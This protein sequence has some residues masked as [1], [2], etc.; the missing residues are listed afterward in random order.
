MKIREFKHLVLA[1]FIA[2]FI[3][4]LIAGLV[5]SFDFESTNQWYVA[6][7]LA[8][9][10]GYG[11]DASHPTALRTPGYPLIMAIMMRLFGEKQ[12]PLMVLLALAGAADTCLCALLAKRLFLSR[13]CALISAY[14]YA[15]TPYIVQKETM[16]QSGFVS[17]GL[18][19]GVY[20][21]FESIYKR[22]LMLTLLCAFSLLFSYLIRPTTGLIPVFI[23]I[24]L[25]LK[26]RRDKDR[27]ILISALLFLS[28]FMAGL[29]PWAVRNSLTFGRPSFGQSNFWQNIYVAN[30]P[31]TFDIYPTIA[32]DNFGPHYMRRDVA[33]YEDEFAN[34][35]WYRKKALAALKEMPKIAVIK[36]AFAKL[37]YLWHWRLVPY[38]ERLGNDPDTGLTLDRPRPLVKELSYSIPYALILIL[39]IKG[40]WLERRRKLLLLFFA[41][42]LLFF[43]LPHMITVAY[44]KYAVAAYFVFI[45]FAARALT[46]PKVN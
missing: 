38:A 34:E 7:N 44:S 17:L 16:S 43:S 3:I 36:N 26:S 32:L 14:I 10:L 13:A 41:G 20:F 4:R 33:P 22:K 42:F 27:K 30:N 5:I 28:V 39:A 31:R 15:F 19:A 29:L 45:I 9:G 46:Y 8:R 24:T 12:L 37:A 40:L 6:R 11:I 18:L 23:F 35:E 21:F 2:S 1:I 25:V